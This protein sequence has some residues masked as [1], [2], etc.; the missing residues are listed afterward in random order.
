M[1][2]SIETL[3]MTE[4]E[5]AA[6]INLIREMAYFNWLD[7]GQPEGRELDCWLKAERHWIEYDYVPRRELD[8]RRPTAP[9]DGPQAS[10]ASAPTDAPGATI[11][12]TA[13]RRRSKQSSAVSGAEPSR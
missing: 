5:R 12:N 13:P 6:C 11:P 8:G 9:H 10:D 3:E 7:A 1:C 2:I 4:Q